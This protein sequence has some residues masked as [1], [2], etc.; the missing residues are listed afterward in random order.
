[1]DL[2]LQNISHKL[3]DFHLKADLVLPSGKLT[4]LLGP[5]GCGKTTLL[6]IISGLYSPGE[7]KVIMGNR[8]ITKLDPRYRKIGMV[9]QDYALFPHMNVMKN[10]CY[11]MKQKGTDAVRKGEELLELV[12][13]GGY[14]K[15]KPEELSGGEKQRVALARALAGSPEILL[16]DEP[17]SA[18]DAKLR[19]A[20]RRQIREIQ[21]ETGITAV[22]VTHDQEEA[23]AISDRI[24]L[25]DGGR[26]KQEGS[27]EELYTMPSD[28]FSGSFIGAAN[29]IP[30]N[31]ISRKQ[32]EMILETDVGEFLTG[33]AFL[34]D[35]A[36]Q[37]NGVIYF[38]PESCLIGT[39]PE[40]TAL[41][42][43]GTVV[44]RE[45]GGDFQYLEVSSGTGII[46]IKT[47][48]ARVFSPGDT[49]EWSVRERDCRFLKI[50]E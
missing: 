7:G 29:L 6:K 14:G 38:R 8:D 9:F 31:R 37:K 23:M 1:M 19:R 24:V 35:G 15:R 12:H 11:G 4:S 33:R 20:L 45:F 43:E 40:K 34:P 17:L 41:A 49:L 3:D 2:K 22:Y 32:E 36:V 44:Y 25:M 10:I 26:I 5:S 50:S 18:L 27:P 30:I 13:L 47:Q 48:T 21:L 39:A 28:T 42:G 46:R 16:L